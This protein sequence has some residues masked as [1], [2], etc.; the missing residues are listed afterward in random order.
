MQELIDVIRAAVTTD[1]TNEQK[2]AG[3]Q[4][5]RTIAAALDVEP[6][7]PIALPG[8]PSASPPA[9]RLSI[10]QVLD[11]VIAR[12]TM[13]A[14]DHDKSPVPA[15]QQ[16]SRL[17]IPVVPAAVPRP[18]AKPSIRPRAPSTRKL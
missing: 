12:L 11:M 2:A 14:N 5:C 8:T 13:I 10:D 18:A 4:A 3:V 9:A 1:A 15:L 6:G 16:Q 7:K 17:R